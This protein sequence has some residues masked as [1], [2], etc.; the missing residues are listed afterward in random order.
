ML[1]LGS[2]T[3]RFGHSP[4]LLPL[5]TVVMQQR[6]TKNPSGADSSAPGSLGVAAVT[7]SPPGLPKPKAKPVP[8]AS[9]ASNFCWLPLC[10]ETLAQGVHLDLGLEVKTDEMT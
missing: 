1:G 7:A 9:A 2:R 8:K 10:S 3:L 4:R 6:I 5:W